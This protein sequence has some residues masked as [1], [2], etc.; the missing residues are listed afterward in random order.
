MAAEPGLGV[1]ATQAGSRAPAQ[2]RASA[3][4]AGVLDLGRPR[5]IHV[6]GIG[7]AGMSAIAEVLATMGHEVT[8][9]DAAPSPVLDRLRGLGMDVAVGHDAAHVGDAEVVTVSTAIRPD[10]AEVV[11][12]RSRGVPVL[13]RAETL[14]AIAA[15]RRTIAVA[16]THGKTTTTAMLATALAGAGLRPSFL[17]GGVIAGLGTGAAW[18]EGEWLV[19]E[20]DES[21]GTFLA[22]A[23]EVAVVTSV[24]PDHLDQWGSFDALVTAF[25]RYA[26]DAPAALVCADDAGAAGVGERVG[27]DTYGTAQAAG[28]RIVDLSLEPGASRFVLERDGRPL[29]EVR[30]PAPGRH[31]ALNA[32]AAVGAALLAGAPFAAVVDALSRY[33]GVGRRFER[34]GEAGGVT[35]V[36]DYA[37]LPAKVAAA[38]AAARGGGW[39]RVVAVFQP[40]RYTRTEALGRDFA[41]SFDGVD[42]LVVTDV[43]GAG[44]EPRP[45]VTGKVVVDAV[46]DARPNQAVAWLPRRQEVVAFLR[47]R[48]R[49]GDVCLTLGAGDITTL[50]GDLLP[51]DPLAAD[52]PAGRS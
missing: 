22:L 35:F 7:G 37:H 33:P 14:A 36:D 39:R 42:L 11:A 31:N 8:G 28:L 47:S 16:G 30:V 9:S 26:G 3:T 49:P 13:R 34:R 21:D 15:T 46:L 45:G 4:Q 52:S 2:H 20:A 18:D 43:Y 17:V 19:V 23:P 5:R 50:A 25:E 51:D 41:T 38:V 12:A 44:E 32:T 10:N 27:A 40:H 6:V 48:L 24:E 1:P 29:G